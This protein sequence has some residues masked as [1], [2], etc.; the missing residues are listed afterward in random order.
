VLRLSADPFL[1]TA[2]LQ[3]YLVFPAQIVQSVESYVGG[4]ESYLKL[5]DSPKY[6]TGTN[7]AE[8]DGFRVQALGGNWALSG[9]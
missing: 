3:Q 8:L 9:W 7:V 4:G 2:N 6:F 1:L 5:V